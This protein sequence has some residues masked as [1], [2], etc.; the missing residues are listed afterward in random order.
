MQFMGDLTQRFSETKIHAAE[1]NP[2]VVSTL[3]NF[4]MARL[5]LSTLK[6][7]FCDNMNP[8]TENEKEETLKSLIEAAHTTQRQLSRDTNISE[9]TIN[10]WAVG[11]KV[12]RID[13]AALV[14]GQLG[15]SLRVLAKALNIDVTRIPGDYSLLELKAIAEELGIE[16]VKD[17]PEDY[18]TLR[19]RRERLSDRQN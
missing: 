5:I 19:R 10:T 4:S 9:G 7:G 13:N 15:V 1:P 16:R 12:P 8:N 6:F 2:F 18:R 11:K 3:P 14:A 17:L